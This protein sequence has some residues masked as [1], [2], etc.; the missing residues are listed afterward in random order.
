MES[1]NL[2]SMKLSIARPGTKAVSA[3]NP[4]L[5]TT[6]TINKFSI[7][8]L[9]SK[10]MGLSHGDHVTI[11]VNDAA[12]DINEMYF[13]TEGISEANQSKL[14]AV[15]K[16]EGVG[17]VLNFNYS[18]V[19][20]KM[21]QFTTDAIELSP[22]ALVDRGLAV[23]RETKEGNTSFV[24]TR[25][26]SFEVGEAFPFEVGGAGEITLYPLVNGKVEEYEPR[27]NDTE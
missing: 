7:N 22:K 13:L 5:T 20:S 16:A 15:N 6:P 12:D 2:E 10:L 9:A 1:L 24:A 14:A 27:T 11:I 21:L 3:S 18:G 8:P 23:E 25:K 4:E 19:W 26:V 17:R